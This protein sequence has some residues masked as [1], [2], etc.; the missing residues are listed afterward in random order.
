MEIFNRP[1]GTEIWQLTEE[2]CGL[3]EDFYKRGLETPRGKAHRD[4]QSIAETFSFNPSAA[5]FTALLAYAVKLQAA[6]YATRHNPL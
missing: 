3:L 6:D 5:T 2:Q 4:F 1:K